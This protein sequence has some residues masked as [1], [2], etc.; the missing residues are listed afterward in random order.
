MCLLSVCK[1]PEKK[2]ENE[3]NRG[4]MWSDLLLASAVTKAFFI[5]FPPLKIIQRQTQRYH[6][7]GPRAQVMDAKAG[8]N[9][10][11]PVY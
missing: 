10:I 6:F 7:T 3:F 1:F 8:T 5:L 9:K 2:E 4:Q 11:F